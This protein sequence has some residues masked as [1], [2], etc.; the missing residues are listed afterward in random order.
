MAKLSPDEY[1]ERLNLQFPEGGRHCNDFEIAAHQYPDLNIYLNEAGGTLFSSASV[2]QMVDKVD[3]CFDGKLILA[4]PYLENTVYGLRIYADPPFVM[5]GW[6]NSKGFGVEPYTELFE[7]LN[8]EAISTEVVSVIKN[9]L[10]A[11]RPVYW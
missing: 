4:L 10:A 3:F 1:A 8:K 9:Y 11:R 7:D 5:V 2:N 6:N